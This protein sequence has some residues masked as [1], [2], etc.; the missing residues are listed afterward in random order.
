LPDISDQFL[1]PRHS[2]SI[3]ADGDLTSLS[4]NGNRDFDGLCVFLYDCNKFSLG[5]PPLG[6][7]SEVF[8]PF[9]EWES[10]IHLTDE[11]GKMDPVN[12]PHEVADISR[13]WNGVDLPGCLAG[14]GPGIFGDLPDATAKLRG[15]K[16]MAIQEEHVRID[17]EKAKGDGAMADGIKC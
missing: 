14:E 1:K 2:E 16:E 7:L 15:K 13:I 17:I 8:G 12:G 6:L 10:G 3:H 4:V 11:T 9:R 5:Q